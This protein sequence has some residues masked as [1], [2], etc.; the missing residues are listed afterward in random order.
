MKMAILRGFVI[1]ILVTI[2]SVG[3]NRPAQTPSGENRAEHSEDINP[4]SVSDRVING[5]PVEEGFAPWQVGLVRSK[6]ST[7]VG[8]FCGGSLISPRWVVTAAHC[9]VGAPRVKDPRDDVQL[10]V[11]SRNLDSGG[12]RVKI[13]DVSIHESYEPFLDKP[14]AN[15]IALIKLSEDVVMP[16]YLLMLDEAGEAELAQPKFNG[17]VIGWGRTGQHKARSKQLLMA[18]LPIVERNECNQRY[19]G[20][21]TDTVICAGDGKKDSCEGDS[22]GPLVVPDNA[23]SFLLA[24][25]VSWGPACARPEEYGIYTRVSKYLSWIRRVTTN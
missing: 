24:G 1:L 11:G 21:I 15:D 4:A 13:E 22:G 25:V 2:G 7:V 3:C 9:L 12:R 10:F 19:G 20:T 23:G 14:Y 8:F 17:Y 16:R 6:E 5:V 18:D